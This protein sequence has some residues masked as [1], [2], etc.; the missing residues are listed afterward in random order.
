[1]W[2]RKHEEQINIQKGPIL[3]SITIIY[4]VTILRSTA[5]LST[6]K[7]ELKPAERTS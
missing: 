2:R 3:G 1:M 7:R 6:D 4:T 5:A